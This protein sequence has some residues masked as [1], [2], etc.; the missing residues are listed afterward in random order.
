MAVGTLVLP[1]EAAVLPDASSGNAPAAIQRVKSSG[2]DP[3][4]FFMQA[5]FDAATDEHLMWSF[6]TPVDYA[7]GLVL[8]C[9]YKMASAT[10]G[11]V[12][13]AAR[14]AAVSEPDATDVDAK[15]FATVNTSAAQ[16]VPGTAGHLNE[17][18]I[19]LTNADSLAAGDFAV[20]WL[21]RDADNAGDTA[22][23]DLE[24]VACSLEFTST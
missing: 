23:G 7:S 11:D 10:T 18:S 6:R 20:V 21:S 9:M 1:I 8:R 4:P 3:K 2:A 22:A 24:L 19:T 5:V 14:V 17:I 15:A 13:L 16:T 12:I